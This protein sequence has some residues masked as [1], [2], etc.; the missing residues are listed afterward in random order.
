MT[1]LKNGWKYKLLNEKLDY[2]TKI[3]NQDL[4]L[5][6][7]TMEK[8]LS[9]RKKENRVRDNLK[10]TEREALY[11]L[12]NYKKHIIPKNVIR[13]QDKASRLV[14]ECKDRYIKEMFSY[15]S[16]KEAFRE[17]ESDQSKMY[18]QN[19][20]NSTKSWEHNITKEDIE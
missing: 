16:N 7:D 2:I 5:F 9:N 19:V 12:A 11:R 17:N 15:L 6:L 1:G 8:E 20:N 3:H 14:I 10:N 13:T 4:E 18:Q